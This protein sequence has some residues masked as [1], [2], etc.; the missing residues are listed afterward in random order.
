V[1]VLA[2]LLKDLGKGESLKPADAA[3]DASR[4]V[5][6]SRVKEISTAFGRAGKEEKRT[7]PL[8]Q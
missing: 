7:L 8:L 5:L 1:T 2:V 6:E 4:S 3:D